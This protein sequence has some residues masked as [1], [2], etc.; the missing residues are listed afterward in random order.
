LDTVTS[1]PEAEQHQ[2]WLVL[3]QAYTDAQL[4]QA[5]G[6]SAHRVRRMRKG[7][8]IRKG[9]RGKLDAGRATAHPETTSPHEPDA[10]A[11]IATH[12]AAD[13]P[14]Q[15]QYAIRGSMD[16]QS[17]ASELATLQDLVSRTPSGVVSF[18]IVIKG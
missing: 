1:Q 2:Q 14:M 6:I 3:A 10:A 11:T 4:A 5:W 16:G 8:G 17:F 12:Q 18:E 9:G 15:L 7:L 13:P